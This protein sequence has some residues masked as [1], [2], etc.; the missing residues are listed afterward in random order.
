MGCPTRS[1]SPAN[2]KLVSRN[3]TLATTTCYIPYPNLRVLVKHPSIFPSNIIATLDPQLRFCLTSKC[4]LLST[5]KENIF[6]S[7]RK[8]QITTSLK[9][10]KGSP[11]SP[12][13]NQILLPLNLVEYFRG[14]TRGQSKPKDNSKKKDIDELQWVFIHGK[15]EMLKWK[16]VSYFLPPALSFEVFGVCG[17]LGIRLT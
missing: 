7:C 10:P 8:N 3:Y 11:R 13:F 2:P 6:E 17:V 12:K 9:E 16:C 14:W 5:S 1:A 15:K 4:L